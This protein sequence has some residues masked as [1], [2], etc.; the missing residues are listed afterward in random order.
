MKELYLL[1]AI[2]IKTSGLILVIVQNTKER[3]QVWY[4]NNLD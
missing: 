4:V 3:K 2:M 1:I